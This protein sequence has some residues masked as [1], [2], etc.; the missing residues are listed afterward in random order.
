MST[1][2]LQVMENDDDSASSRAAKASGDLTENENDWDQRTEAKAG[3][4]RTLNFAEKI[5]YVL[6]N[7]LCQGM[8]VR[9]FPIRGTFA[10]LLLHLNLNR[11]SVIS[12]LSLSVR[13]A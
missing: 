13:A 6:S 11:S 4:G 10:L 5:Y 9:S 12:T 3:P 7:E 2:Q 1:S 8:Y